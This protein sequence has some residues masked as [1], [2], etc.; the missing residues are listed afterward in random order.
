[1]LKNYIIVGWPSI[2]D[3]YHSNLR[4]CWSYRDDLAVI[5]GVVM[6][7]R[8]IVIPVV[9]KQQVSYQFHLNNMGIEKNK[10][11]CT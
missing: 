6:K 8:C 7:V 2:K 1:M 5:D 11:T 3:E 4:P 10:A 9:L